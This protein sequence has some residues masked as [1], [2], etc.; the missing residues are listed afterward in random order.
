MTK[1]IIKD[2]YEK[3]FYAAPEFLLSV[4]R[5]QFFIIS[6]TSV[7]GKNICVKANVNSQ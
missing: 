1:I 7:I 4:I 6:A 5:Q 3:Y 2:F